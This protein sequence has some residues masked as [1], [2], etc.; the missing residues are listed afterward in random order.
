VLGFLIV[1]LSSVFFCF[2]NVIVRVL[3]NQHAIL[4]LFQTGGFVTPTLQNSF[5]LMFMRMLLVVP[6]MAFLAPKL[7]P[8]TWKD[9]KQL[10][11]LE[12]RP[13]L[14]QSVGCGVL[15][16]LYWQ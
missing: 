4:G 1:L 15:M 12:Q 3:F 2:H 5:L 11:N 10:G 8:A 13:L 9:I 6:L 14:L 7:Y 16:F